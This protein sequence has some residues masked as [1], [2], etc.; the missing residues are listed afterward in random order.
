MLLL[1]AALPG[2]LR[3]LGPARLPRAVRVA[4][5]VVQLSRAEDAEGQ[6]LVGG[7]AREQ[8]AGAEG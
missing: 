2:P 1:P 5:G 6:C 8:S 7:K 4:S 3:G